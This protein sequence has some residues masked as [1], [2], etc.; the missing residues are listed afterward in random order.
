MISRKLR[1]GAAVFLMTGLE[2]MCIT[3]GY[4]LTAKR[5]APSSIFVLSNKTPR[6]CIERGWAM[7]DS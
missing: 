1:L 7:R 3:E 4:T 6:R 5:K 2:N